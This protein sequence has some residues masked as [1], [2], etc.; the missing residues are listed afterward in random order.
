MR[1]NEEIF[2]YGGKQI[3]IFQDPTC[4]YCWE[5]DGRVTRLALEFEWQNNPANERA[6]AIEMAKVAID[7][8]V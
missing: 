4:T 3:H 2:K 5:I 8:N 7:R 6:I 1:Y